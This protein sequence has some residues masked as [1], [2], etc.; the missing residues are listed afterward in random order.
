MTRTARRRIFWSARCETP[1]K[2]KR[3]ERKPPPLLLL[4][5]AAV[6]RVAEMLQRKRRTARRGVLT[7]REARAREAEGRAR[8]MGRV[9]RVGRV[10]RARARARAKEV[11]VRGFLGVGKEKEKEEAEEEVV[12]G[13]VVEEGV[14]GIKGGGWWK[15]KEKEPQRYGLWREILNMAPDTPTILAINLG[16]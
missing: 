6:L 4:P 15:W 13:E 2:G 10:G 3:R 8:D 14:A 1:S 7:K 12:V 16:N 9:A 5:K 11:R